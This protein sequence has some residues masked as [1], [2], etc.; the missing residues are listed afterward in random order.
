MA[1]PPVH[2]RV[3]G[4]ELT[5]HTGA[6]VVIWHVRRASA[7][8]VLALNCAKSVYVCVSVCVT[9]IESEFPGIKDIKASLIEY[10][11]EPNAK[12]VSEAYMSLCCLPLATRHLH[13]LGV[14]AGFCGLQRPL[15]LTV[16]RLCDP[17]TLT[18]GSR[19]TWGFFAW[20]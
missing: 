15:V 12:N 9:Q 6:K 8:F 11:F 13:T 18:D 10:V 19:R 7:G 1:C 2:V 4:Y 16:H 5:I 20:C 17:Q 14:H 3:G